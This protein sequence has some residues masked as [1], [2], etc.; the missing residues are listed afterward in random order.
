MFSQE[1]E[2]GL[3]PFAL[4]AP[5]LEAVDFVWPISLMPV[6]VFG[7]LGSV[8]VDPWGFVL[9]FGL[10]VWVALLALLLLVSLGS[11]FLSFKF[12]EKDLSDNGFAFV[13]ITLRQCEYLFFF[14]MK[15]N[16]LREIKW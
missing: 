10:W 5:R 7:G 9:P 16:R 13:S 8:E 15:D 1:A 11:F 14:C 3:G 2:V 12:S 4:N 6:K